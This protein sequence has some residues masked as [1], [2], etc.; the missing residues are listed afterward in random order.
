MNQTPKSVWLVFGLV[1]LAMLAVAVWWFW[2]RTPPLPEG[3]IQTN[4]RIEGDHHAVAAKV[5]GKVVEVLAR[6]GDSVEKGKVLVRLDDAQVHA[7]VD[8]ARQAV[9]AL[10]AQR[11][12]A[13]TALQVGRKELPLA[14]QTAEANLAHARAQLASARSNADQALRDAARFRKL[15]ESGTVDPHRAEQMVLAG[16]VAANQA[17]SAEEAVRVVERQLA[18]ARLGAERLRAKEDEVSALAAQTD[19]ARAAVREA[20]AFMDD[21]SVVTPVAGTLTQRLVSVGEVVAA[22]A[23]LFDIVD[24]DRL[25]LK[26]Y[27]PEHQLGKVRLGAAARIYTD[28]FPDAPLAATVRYIA[29]Q[30]Q[31]TP[32]EVQTPDERVKLVYEVRLYLDA[33]PEHRYTPGLPADAVIRWREDAPWAKPRW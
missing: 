15:A 23:P 13:Q 32:K 7:K 22:G 29:S 27:V 18:Q 2:L 30:A 12:A 21:L 19:Q 24:L 31:F 10:E 9:N 5:P 17:R 3:L 25:Y 33:N 6:E 8:Q 4:G 16:E 1:A 28:A 26:V 11:K 14:T 20:E